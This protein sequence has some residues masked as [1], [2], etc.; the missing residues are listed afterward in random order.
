[1]DEVKRP[2][3]VGIEIR[4][5]EDAVHTRQRTD[6]RGIDTLDHGMAM[7]RAYHD[8]VQLPGHI[9]IVDIAPVTGQKPGSCAARR[10]RCAMHIVPRWLRLM[11]PARL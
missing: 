7:R 9:D 5:R 10:R 2:E 4:C 6:D 8:A 1:M 3:A 11:T